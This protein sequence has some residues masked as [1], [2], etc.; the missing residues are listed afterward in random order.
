MITI[1]THQGSYLIIDHIWCHNIIYLTIDHIFD[2]WSYIWLLIIHLIIDHILVGIIYLTIDYASQPMDFEASSMAA[3][4]SAGDDSRHAH[5][6][7]GQC[8]P[9]M[10]QVVSPPWA[11]GWAKGW[12]WTWWMC[13]NSRCFS[14]WCTELVVVAAM[15]TN[16]YRIRMLEI[17]HSW[18]C[19]NKPLEQ[20]P[21]LMSCSMAS[22][23][24]WRDS[25]SISSVGNDKAACS[26]WIS[27]NK[28]ISSVRY[29]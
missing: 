22:G 7:L 29:R 25:G 5:E 20:P 10:S 28:E 3:R 16:G 23:S 6:P 11:Q 4:N 8:C 1:F 9:Q 18:C 12:W 26:T 24:K 13:G 17:N 2:H 27:S 21:R 14:C 15:G 19:S